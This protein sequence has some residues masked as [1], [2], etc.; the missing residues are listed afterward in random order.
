[1]SEDLSEA[2]RR[3]RERREQMRRELEESKADEDDAAAR[4]EARRR[5]REARR[6]QREQEEEEPA[7][8]RSSRRRDQDTEE[9][10]S[11]SRDG[12]G[13]I[14]S[15]RRREVEKEEEERKQKEKEEAEAAERQ[16]QREEEER[17]RQEEEE[18]RQ[19]EEEEEEER[20]RQER[21]EARRRRREQ[22]E[23]EERERARRR[24]DQ[25][26]NAPSRRRRGKE[27]EEEA[28]PPQ[29]NEEAE[30]EEETIF[31]QMSP[32]KKAAILEGLAAEF[33]RIVEARDAKGQMVAVSAQ[34]LDEL[35]LKVRSLRT[36][37]RK[38]E[39]TSNA[40]Q[41]QQK[42]LEIKIKNNENDVKRLKKDLQAAEA[43]NELAIKEGKK[44]APTTRVA[45]TQK[46]AS[47][48][49][50]ASTEKASKKPEI[51]QKVFSLERRKT[52]GKDRPDV[53]PKPKWQNLSLRK[54]EGPKAPLPT[55]EVWKSCRP[56][57]S[58]DL[59]PTS[60]LRKRENVD[61][62][63]IKEAST[64]TSLPP[65]VRPR[66]RTADN[67]S[68]SDMSAQRKLLTADL[69]KSLRTKFGETPKISSET[70]PCAPRRRGGLEDDPDTSHTHKPD[71]RKFADH[72]RN[73]RLKT[74]H[75][76]STNPV[77]GLRKRRDVR[78]EL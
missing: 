33:R 32:Q 28:T 37:V 36:Q 25:E 66:S 62:K 8:A 42:E 53:K 3:R 57:W 45:P 9:T 56:D 77:R 14:S 55:V 17:R 19:R 31:E 15:R 11:S 34:E 5:E 58:K 38:A 46:K 35:D 78:S 41:K 20:R 13:Y 59:S 68:T 64:D 16:R 75:R 6:K 70:R 21:E 7:P 65:R 69:Q 23:E 44:V 74:R 61:M 47:P 30:E 29:D 54:T 4:R 2:A 73:V 72:R 1:M 43:E 67:R 26:D 76:P 63:S 52:Q 24:K 10:D 48:D 40:L 27:E 51:R 18:E 39:E 12:S 71:V 50:P 49:I 22:E 60:R